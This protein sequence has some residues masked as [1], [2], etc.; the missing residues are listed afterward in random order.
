M[1]IYLYLK[2][3]NKTGLK[4]LGKTIQDP[5]VYKGSGVVWRAHIKKHGYDVTTEILFE[6]DD[7]E[8]FEQV[9]L[10][11]SEQYNIVESS[12]FA[13]LVPEQGDGIPPTEEFR[14][15]ISD[16][17]KLVDHKGVNNPFYGKKHTEEHKKYLS[18]LALEN[19]P[20]Y[21]EHECPHCGKIGHG[22]VM[23]RWHLD[24]CKHK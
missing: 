21:I 13:N 24:N 3:H 12:D 15:Q 16:R 8:E 10:E 11:Y 2:T 22:G 14:K 4:Y 19:N 7:I 18:K 6:T 1:S 17:M 5:Y 20:A 23:K 9:A